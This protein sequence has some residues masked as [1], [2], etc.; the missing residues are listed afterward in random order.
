M[1]GKGSNNT[2]NAVLNLK[3]INFQMMKTNIH[4]GYLS[5]Y[6]SQFEYGFF[7]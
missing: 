7:H 1:Q 5:Q 2:K 3:Q 4:F 6:V